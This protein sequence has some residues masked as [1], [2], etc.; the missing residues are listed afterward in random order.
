MKTEKELK[1]AGFTESGTTRYRQSTTEYCDTLF[2]KA[3]TFGEADKADGLPREVT[4][5]HV[6]AAAH[7]IAN[8][9]GR[10]QP[11][12]VQIWCQVG[13]YVTAAFAGLGAGKLDQTWGIALFGI[14]LTLG[15]ICFIVRNTQK[16]K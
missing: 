11:T 3:V 16:Q 10:D 5:D 2:Q 1:D 15:V 14:S 13:E 9:Y 4:H 8:S 12:K 7:A 6:K